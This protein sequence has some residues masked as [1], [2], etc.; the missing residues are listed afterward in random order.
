MRDINIINKISLIIFSI[1]IF[2]INCYAENPENLNKLKQFIIETN[3]HE[4]TQYFY[5]DNIS[6]LSIIEIYDVLKINFPDHDTLLI[7]YPDFEIYPEWIPIILS[8]EIKR[9]IILR[10]PLVLAP[11]GSTYVFYDFGYLLNTSLLIYMP[12]YNYQ[13]IIQ[14]FIALEKVDDPRFSYREINGFSLSY[15]N[16]NENSNDTRNELT[17]YMINIKNILINNFSE[18][19]NENNF[20]QNRDAFLERFLFREVLN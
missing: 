9:N 5:I 2:S 18:T 1:F 12:F 8:E 19:F 13:V 11:S 4:S 16:I 6:R 3:A 14:F 15:F 17:E 10:P 7:F 20:F